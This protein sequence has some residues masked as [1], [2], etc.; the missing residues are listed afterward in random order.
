MPFTKR[1][2]CC[3]PELSHRERANIH[4]RRKRQENPE[5]VRDKLRAWRA[6]EAERNKAYGRKYHDARKD[7]PEYRRKARERAAAWLKK[8]PDLAKANSRTRAKQWRDENPEEARRRVRA[9]S[10]KHAAARKARNRARYLA[11]KER[12]AE[13]QRE[14]HRKHPEK[15]SVAKG[16]RRA[17]MA[18]A[19]GSG[20]SASAWR[21]RMNEFGG[22]C[23]YCLGDATTMDHVVPLAGGGSHDIENVVP[24]CKTCNSRKGSKSLLQFVMAGGGVVT[25]P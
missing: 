1:C 12:L 25:W 20:V 24:A 22:K 11:N 21:A 23:A 17:R 4:A 3:G 10:K 7:D 13:K 6:K 5:A 9:S 18:Q 16:R 2:T 19:P 14:Y 8:H 15:L